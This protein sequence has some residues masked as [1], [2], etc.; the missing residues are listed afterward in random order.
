MHVNKIDL[1][2]ILLVTD[3]GILKRK[4]LCLVWGSKQI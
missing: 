2:I 4:N 3:V 1:E